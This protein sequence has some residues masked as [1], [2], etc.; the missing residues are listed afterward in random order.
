MATPDPKKLVLIED[1]L[2]MR[3][4]LRTLLELE[5]FQVIAPGDEGETALLTAIQAEDPAV[6]LLDVHLRDANGLEVLRKLR[7]SE[8]T[9]TRARVVMTS[10]MDLSDQCLAAGADSFLLKPYMPADLIKHLKG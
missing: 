6:I 3:S 10:G 8:P 2:S 7:Q 4:L 9:G 1:D 5:G